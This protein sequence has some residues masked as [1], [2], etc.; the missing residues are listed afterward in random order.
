MTD[1]DSRIVIWIVI[2]LAVATYAKYILGWSFKEFIQILLSEFKDLLNGDK[3]AGA[4]NAATVICG[5]LLLFGALLI[6]SFVGFF[7]LSG[8]LPSAG[9][10]TDSASGAAIVILAGGLLCVRFIRPKD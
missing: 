7:T 3:T 8:Y 5:F 6:P 10:V 1:A 4:V 9:N 2:A